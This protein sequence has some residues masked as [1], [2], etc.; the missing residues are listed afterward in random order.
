MKV[1]AG[2]FDISPD[3]SRAGVVTFSLRAKHS[4]KMSDHTDAASFKA[5]VDAI[6]L[7]G[8]TTRIDR[9][10]RLTQKELFAPANGGRADVRDVLIMLTDGTQTKSAGAED[11]GDVM[12][13]IR[14]TGVE[15]IVIGIG[16]GTDADEL[17]HMAGGK[18]KAYSAK[19]F[20][21]LIGGDFVTK[22]TQQTCKAGK[23]FL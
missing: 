13:E 8:L 15:T 19:S 1:L 12:A 22:L 4:I 5:A 17:D 14:K 2:A 18:G 20:D 16:T 21:E 6:P 3:G 23:N 11:P 10:L 9:A 7:M